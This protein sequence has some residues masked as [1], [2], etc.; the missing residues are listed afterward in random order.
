MKGKGPLKIKKDDSDKEDILPDDVLKQ[1]IKT[2]LK[3]SSVKEE[4][5]EENESKPNKKGKKKEKVLTEAKMRHQ[6]YLS[7]LPIL[8]AR[9]APTA[10]HTAIHGIKNVDIENFLVEIGFSSY[11][12]FDINN[13]PSRL[14]R[15]VVKNFDAETCRLNLEDGK[16]IEATVTKVRELLGIP[17]GGDSLLSLE[18]RPVED[19]FENVWI[20]QFQP[21]SAKKIRV[22]EI[23][24]KLIESKEVDFLFKVN[25][26]TL[27]TNTMGMCAGLQGK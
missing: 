16:S 18:T 15:C 5:D 21:K 22:N 6:D 14:G 20:R 2:L 13:I 27:F 7:E 26:L 24:K 10:L 1:L 12:K 4:T 11:F 17:I 8:H 25:F 3:N 9:T 19:D 23:A